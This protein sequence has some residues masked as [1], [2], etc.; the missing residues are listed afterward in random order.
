MSGARARLYLLGKRPYD[1]IA[2]RTQHV[3]LPAR[4]SDPRRAKLRMHARRINAGW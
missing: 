1:P 4:S 3:S 2:P